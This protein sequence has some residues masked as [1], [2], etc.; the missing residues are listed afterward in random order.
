MSVP[1]LLCRTALGLDSASRYLF[2]AM[3]PFPWHPVDLGLKL[4]VARDRSLCLRDIR[5]LRFQTERSICG[6]GRRAAPS[7]WG[8]H[9]PWATL[10]R[11]RD[12]TEPRGKGF[13]RNPGTP[14]SQEYPHHRAL[15]P[16]WL[17]ANPADG[18]GA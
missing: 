15:H 5:T 1:T 10:Q 16:R 6:S 18:G 8:D 4:A 14:P 2:E 13:A 7:G 9:R 17:R 11:G 12:P 3:N